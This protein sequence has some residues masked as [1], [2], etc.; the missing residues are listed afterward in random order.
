M[1]ESYLKAAVSIKLILVKIRRRK[2]VSLPINLRGAADDSQV[3][4]DLAH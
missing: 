4:R 2:K 3:V 1:L